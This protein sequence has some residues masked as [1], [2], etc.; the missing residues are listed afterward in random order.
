MKIY[1][2]ACVLAFIASVLLLPVFLPIILLL[3]IYH[4][5]VRC[6][7]YLKGAIPL[8]ADDA[9]WQQDRST[10]LHIV[11]AVMFL[12]G[13]LTLKNLEELVNQRLVKSK[14]ANGEKLCPRLTCCIDVLYGQYV[15]IEDGAFKIENHVQLWGGK[16][17]KTMQDLENVISE[18]SSQIL[19]RK[20]PLW[21]FISIPTP[22]I[23]DSHVIVF[24]IH[25][26]Y[27]DGVALTRLFVN[28]LFDVPLNH[29]EPIKFSTK[30][31]F[32]MLTKAALVGPLTVI[33]RCLSPRD[34]SEIH[35]SQLNGKKLV[36]WSKKFEL[37]TVKEIKNRTETTVNDVMTSCLSGAL[38]RYLQDHSEE[39]PKDVWAA[40]PVDIRMDKSSMKFDNRFALVFLRAPV[41]KK[42]CIEQ[43]YETKKRMDEIKRSA[44]PFVAATT[45]Q[46]LML[47]PHFISKTILDIFSSKV[48]CVL[49][50]VP[51]PQFPLTIGGNKALGGIFWPPARANIAIMMSIF[52]YNG[53]IGIGVMTD[54][55]IIPKP[56]EIVANFEKIFTEMCE[57]MNIVKP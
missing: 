6:L 37:A 49:S 28:N 52:S 57:T 31:R 10:N 27:A 1:W 25:H 26:S 36:S 46:L 56:S 39:K 55:A 9:V 43:L 17:P 13:R 20:K 41:S 16:Q 4:G 5:G 8:A 3:L 12:A 35:G 2:A 34:Y 19:Q 7:I 50:N 29:H 11:N 32:L 40:V 53:Q 44:E 21:E 54:E 47:L 33:S 45:T 42:D 51:G 30:K 14:R 38:R 48:S 18:I 15:W 23:N 24:R 22:D